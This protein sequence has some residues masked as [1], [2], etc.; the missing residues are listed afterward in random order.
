MSWYIYAVELRGE[1]NGFRRTGLEVDGFSAPAGYGVAGTV[2]KGR[3]TLP[4]QTAW[5]ACH[6]A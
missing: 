2:G 3:L 1:N 5:K 4:R 6:L